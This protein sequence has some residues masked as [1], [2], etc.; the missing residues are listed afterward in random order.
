MPDISNFVIPE[1]RYDGLYKTGDDLARK[2]ERM[3]FSE[4]G[5]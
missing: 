5:L 1:S 3:P 4:T 2:A